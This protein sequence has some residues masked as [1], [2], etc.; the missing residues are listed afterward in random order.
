MQNKS[1]PAKVVLVLLC[2]GLPTKL[3]FQIVLLLYMDWDYQVDF[4][5]RRDK[6]GQ[7]FKFLFT[8]LRQLGVAGIGYSG[9]V[10][11]FGGQVL[12]YKVVGFLTVLERIT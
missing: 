2:I 7:G 6:S 3:F 1:I 8:C 9:S 12:A 10:V 4:H 5:Q 11:I